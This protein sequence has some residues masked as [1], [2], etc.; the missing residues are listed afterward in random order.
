MKIPCAVLIS[1]VHY[2]LSTLQLADSAFQ[3]AMLKAYE[4]KVPLIDCGDITNDKAML[5]AE[6]VNQLLTTFS[7]ASLNKV[8]IYLLIGN[9]SLL[10]HLGDEHALHF[11]KGL[12][13][14]VDTTLTLPMG[15]GLDA[16]RMRLIAYQS[17]PQKFK[18]LIDPKGWDFYPEPGVILCHQGIQGADM[19][20]YVLDKSSIDP[21]IFKG[22]RVISGHYHKRQDLPGTNVSYLGNP[23]T[24][25][26][27][28]SDHGPKG[29]NILYSDGSL[30]LV[31]LN[32]PKHVVI[33]RTVAS[34]LDPIEGLRP[35]DHLMIKVTGSEE[36]LRLLNKQEIGLRH[37]GHANFRLDS[38]SSTIKETTKEVVEELTESELLDSLI[39][40]LDGTDEYKTDLKSTW[41]NLVSEN[42]K[43]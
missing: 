30:E 5:R 34:V 13:T 9:H 2:S 39:E 7:T 27:G 8:P 4:L 10:N 6:V 29:F 22:R 16:K 26:F 20:H 36:E 43:G 32:L 42:S 41:R 38:I 40:T 14:I 11:L 18:E 33:E 12:C 31:P 23:Y 24:L 28:E 19:G 25:G 17:N 21:A 15:P 3:S 1:D 37:L 35:K